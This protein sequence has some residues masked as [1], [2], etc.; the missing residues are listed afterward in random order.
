M[1]SS[2]MSSSRFSRE[3]SRLESLA[4]FDRIVDHEMEDLDH[5]QDVVESLGL[6]VVPRK[7]IE[8]QGVLV[9]QEQFLHLEDLDVSLPDFDRQVVGDERSR[10]T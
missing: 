7:T 8:D 5:V 9:R 6:E 4:R 10:L 1:T 3:R 2:F